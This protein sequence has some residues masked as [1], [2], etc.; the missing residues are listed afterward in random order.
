MKL[1]TLSQREADSGIYPAFYSTDQSADS[2]GD[3]SR[4][5]HAAGDERSETRRRQ[6]TELRHQVRSG[7]YEI[8]FAQLVRILASLFLKRR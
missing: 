6:V 8:P 3:N 1:D 4:H 7:T 2:N 5:D